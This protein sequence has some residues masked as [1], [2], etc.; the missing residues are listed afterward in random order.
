MFFSK[1][2]YGKG[3]WKIPLKKW[4]FFIETFHKTEGDTYKSYF[5]IILFLAAMSSSR[6][7][8]VFGRK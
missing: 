6:S 7:D 4:V 3:V 8:V 2:S 5:Q 1:K